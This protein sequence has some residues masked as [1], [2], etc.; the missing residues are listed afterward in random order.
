MPE[1]EVV[2]PGKVELDPGRVSRVAVP[3]PGRISRVLVGL[4][5]AV[6]A[7]QPLILLE[8]TEVS[9]VMSALRQASA[10]LS[11]A[12]ATLAKS[13]ADL[14]RSRDLL[15]DRA[16]AQKDVLAAEATVAQSKAAVEQAQAA[17]DEAMRKL[18]LLGL[19]P[20][21]MD[22]RVTV[23]AP[24]SGKVVEITARQRRLSERHH[25]AGDDHRGP[26]HACGSPPTFPKTAYVSS[27]P[28]NRWR[29]RCPHSPAN[30]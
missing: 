9:G 16:I 12:N 23:K 4:G 8:S 30:A 29:S 20:G 24:A 21:A 19:Q 3:V 2:A 13:Q 7:G 17:G 15:A 10:N 1:D 6:T 18:Q 25:H 28:A 27:T 11:Q 26:E 5:D 22:Q 14:A